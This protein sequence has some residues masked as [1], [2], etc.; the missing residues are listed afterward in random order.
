MET[1]L[2]TGASG[3][4][5]RHVVRHLLLGGHEV[6]AVARRVG[7]THPGA[8]WHTLDLHDRDATVRLVNRLRPDR[9]IHLAWNV[10]PGF[11]TSTDNLAWVGASLDLVHSLASVGCRRLILA[12]TCYEYAWSDAPCNEY[13]TPTCPATLYGTAKLAVNYT[14]QMAA[15]ELGIEIA[16]GRIFFLFGPGEPPEKLVAHTI[17][18]LLQ[19]QRAACTPGEQVRDYLYVD[20]VAASFT[21]LLESDVTGVVNIASGEAL[22]V[23]DLVSAIGDALGRPDLIGLGDLPPAA[24]EPRSIVADVHRL[25][26]EVG[27]GERTDLEVAIDRSIEWWRQELRAH[28]TR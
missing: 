18:S 17:R 4:I 27:F 5:G 20:D 9:A 6:H 14:A 11:V 12:G 26:A 28:V 21:A 13:T 15:R 25:R 23:C 22:R 19:G 3:F 7:P 16:T 2:V 10:E 24:R 8:T 1:T